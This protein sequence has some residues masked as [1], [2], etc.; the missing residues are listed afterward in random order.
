MTTESKD[1]SVMEVM[2][3]LTDTKINLKEVVDKFLLITYD[4][5][6]TDEGDKARRE[7]LAKAKAI[8]AAQ[9]TESVYLLPW[10]PEAE[11]LALGISKVKQGEVLIWTSQPTDSSLAKDITNRYDEGL[12]PI[13]DEISERLDRMEE[14]RIQHRDGRADKMVPKTQTMLEN[15][16]KAILRRGSALLFLRLGLLTRRFQAVA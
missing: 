15:M 3:R 4:L 11:L 16:E 13:M 7:F 9:H 14:H 8:G 12:K 5:P 2:A 10:T 6:H 1:T